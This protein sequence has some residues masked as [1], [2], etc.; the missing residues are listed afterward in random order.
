MPHLKLLLAQSSI[1]AS[2]CRSVNNPQ[3]APH[4]IPQRDKLQI[5][6]GYTVAASTTAITTTAQRAR[7][8]DLLQS[9]QSSG[10][11]QSAEN[12]TDR[13]RRLTASQKASNRSRPRVVHTVPL[14][15]ARSVVCVCRPVPAR[16]VTVCVHQDIYE[17]RKKYYEWNVR[18]AIL[19]DIFSYAYS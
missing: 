2:G 5:C 6:Q 11:P 14:L 18:F 19:I 4:Q 12:G 15:K 3:T 17:R 8:N 9:K 13:A 1:S 7:S 16:C 10:I